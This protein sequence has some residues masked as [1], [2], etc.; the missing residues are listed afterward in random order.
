MRFILP[1][2]FMMPKMP[3]GK[4]QKTVT[5]KAKLM[6][7]GACEAG[8]GFVGF[9]CKRGLNSKFIIYMH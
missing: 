3:K 5:K 6:W 7:S 8:I 1:N 4:Q 2:A 9:F